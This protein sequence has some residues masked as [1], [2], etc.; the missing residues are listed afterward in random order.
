M[1]FQQIRLVYSLGEND[2][3]ELPTNLQQDYTRLQ[4]FC[5]LIFTLI[6]TPC[7]ATIA[8][9]RKESGAWKWAIL[10]FAGLTMTAWIITFIIYQAGSAIGILTG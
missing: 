5:I 9:T 2:Q 3:E 4:G 7:I 6:S 10:Q 1:D 8:V